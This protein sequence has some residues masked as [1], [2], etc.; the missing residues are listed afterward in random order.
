MNETDLQSEQTVPAAVRPATISLSLPEFLAW[1]LEKLE[2]DVKSMDKSGTHGVQEIRIIVQQL[3]KDF[4]QHEVEHKENALEQKA[5][6]R[7]MVGTLVALIVP[8]YPTIIWVLTK[9]K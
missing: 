4:I 7:F 8:L 9:G 5:S 3:Q 6:R 1:R 2:Q